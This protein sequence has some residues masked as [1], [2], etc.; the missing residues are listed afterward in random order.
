MAKKQKEDAFAALASETGGQLLSD[1]GKSKYYIDSGN[2]SI[3]WMCSGRFLGGGFPG[4]R[5]SELYGPQAS[6]KSLLGNCVL[7]G[8]QKMGGIA[9]YLDCERSSNADFM[10]AAAHVDTDKLLVYELMEFDQIERKVI[11]V[12]KKIRQHF[13]VDKPIAFLWDSI[14]TVMCGRES[15]Y[16]DLPDNYT[17][18][19]FKKIV[20]SNEKPGERARAAGDCLR[21]LNPFLS[22][23]DAT[24]VIINQVRSAIGGY[25]NPE[26]TG[27]GGKALP[28][29]ASLRLR[30]SAK[31]HFTNKLG[32][33]IGVGLK[34][35]NKKNR[36]FTPGLE[37]DEVQLFFN[38]GIN[39]TGGLLSSLLLAERITGKAGNYSVLEPYSNGMEVKF[40]ATKEQN[41]VPLEVLLKCPALVDA[42]SADEV[43]EYVSEYRAAF[44]LVQSGDLV[45]E[46]TADEDDEEL[47]ELL[48]IG[49]RE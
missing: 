2:L 49:G 19:D 11:S 31:K 26:V 28:F 48:G 15:K 9:V 23:N 21:R 46:S 6:A 8:C 27:G 39:P 30:T 13:G 40:K 42:N 12:T 33:P 16:A 25:G 18:A 22:D 14:S 5:L 24:M 29:Y 7:R 32:F 3:N 1:V 47:N 38:S 37:V 44:D 35:A 20:G 34:F 41:S 17:Q 43:E 36:S 10:R 4:G 45:E